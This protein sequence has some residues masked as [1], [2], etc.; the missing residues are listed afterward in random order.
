[1]KN[2]KDPLQGEQAAPE[3]TGGRG[4]GFDYVK[5]ELKALKHAVWA[6]KEQLDGVATAD[7]DGETAEPH[8]FTTAQ[9]AA[10]WQVSERTI[11]YEIEA[12]TL[13][14]FYVRGARRFTI[15]AVRAYERKASGRRRTA[16]RRKTAKKSPMRH[17]AAKAA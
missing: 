2:T 17:E 9:L 7:P 16:R 15:D 11:D 1:M 14:P 8:A 6:L 5:V 12:G 10:R 13:V 3:Y 4:S